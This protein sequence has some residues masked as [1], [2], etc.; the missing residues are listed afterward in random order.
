MK[1]EAVATTTNVEAEAADWAAAA[2]STAMVAATAAAT[3]NAEAGRPWAC[4]LQA[5]SSVGG[6][7]SDGR[8]RRG[9]G[10]GGRWAVKAELEEA[11]GWSR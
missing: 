1:V 9:R 8:G 6:G 11:D 10:G 4:N 7:I 5:T 2:A 3:M